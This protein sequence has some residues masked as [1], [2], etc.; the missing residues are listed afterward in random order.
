MATVSQKGSIVHL[1]FVDSRNSSGKTHSSSAR[2][3]I[4]L[5]CSMVVLAA[6]GTG[7]SSDSNGEGHQF[8]GESR[9]TSVPTATSDPITASSDELRITPEPT[10]SPEEI[11]A[12]RGAPQ[13]AYFVIDGDLQAYDT[14]ARTF[15]P[16]NLA[17]DMTVLDFASSPT[18]DRV[19]ILALVDE[20][21]VVQFYGANGEPLGDAIPLSISYMPVQVSP[22][23]SPTASPEATP[24]SDQDQM[25]LFVTWVPQGNA[26][27]VSGPGVMQQ[28]S[29]SGAIMPI[30]RTGVTGT[31]V[32]GLWSPM[33]S[34]IAILTQMMDGHQGVFMLDS[35]RAE[36]RQLEMLHLEPE[37]GLSNL[38]W[39]PNG[40]GLVL[41]VGDNGTGDLMHGQ[42]YVYKFGDST[43][44]L[45]ATSGQGGPAGTIS[46]AAVSPDGNSVAYAIMVQD[47][48][49]WHLHSLWVRPISGGSSISIPLDSN[50]PITDLVW[51]AEGLIWQQENGN[52]TV[53]DGALM[54]RPLGEEPMATPVSSPHS[55]PV[56]EVTPRG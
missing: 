51:T 3:L 29:M 41:V 25:T 52:T 27:V 5:L 39:L 7:S 46:H 50:A 49:Q 26:V 22:V 32:K 8:A 43:P 19:G 2:F 36:A 38:Q 34:Q 56:V 42:L 55:T 12:L 4:V 13:F 37:Q 28:V 9:S 20:D 24:A 18:G 23:A 1:M 14:V 54:P 40:L 35:G 53:V 11:F 31:V 45:V 48:N 30:S 16:V 21:V 6:C 15:T 44:R 33:D 47:Q 10:I 17:D